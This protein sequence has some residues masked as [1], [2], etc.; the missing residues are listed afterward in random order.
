LIFTA[1]SLTCWLLARVGAKSAIAI[2]PWWCSIIICANV[3]SASLWVVS[4]V[5]LLSLVDDIDDMGDVDEIAVMDVMDDP[6]E[7]VLQAARVSVAAAAVAAAQR[8]KR[9]F[10]CGSPQERGKGIQ[11][12]PE[13]P[14]AVVPASGCAKPAKRTAL[15]AV[16]QIRRVA[17]AAGG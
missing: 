13:T 9:V 16:C 17:R 6:G 11:C 12:R 5:T 3:T 7:V 2:A 10:T 15:C 8:R 4:A 14:S 1:R